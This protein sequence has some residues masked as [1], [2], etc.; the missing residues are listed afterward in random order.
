MKVNLTENY[1]RIYTIEDLERAKKVIK[2]EKD[3]EETAKGWAEYAVREAL[4]NTDDGLV[5][6][7]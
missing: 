4:K 1:K 2:C 5:R 7:I 6:V 3:D